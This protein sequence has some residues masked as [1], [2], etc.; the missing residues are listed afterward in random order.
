MKSDEEEQ[1]Q[2]LQEW[3][4]EIPGL[5]DVSDW[6]SSFIVPC[7]EFKTIT[8]RSTIPG[9]HHKYFWYNIQ[10]FNNQIFFAGYV[11]AVSL[12]ALE[13]ICIP[14]MVK[15]RP[16]PGCHSR[17]RIEVGE[18]TNF[19][20]QY[21]FYSFSEITVHVHTCISTLR[22]FALTHIL[23]YLLPFYC[24]SCVGQKRFS[25]NSSE[26]WTV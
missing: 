20:F 11:L 23:L 21:V 6:R 26:L 24:N 3:S 22:R 2:F 19:I 5:C 10:F 1:R 25:R 13:A 14:H 16:L 8:C 12:W 15:K 9:L 4:T 18:I 17:N 7:Y